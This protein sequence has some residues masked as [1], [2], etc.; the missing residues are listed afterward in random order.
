MTHCA[1]ARRQVQGA[2]TVIR[3]RSICTPDEPGT[4]VTCDDGKDNDCDGLIDAAD[5][6]CQV[7]VPDETPEQSCFDGNDNDCDELVD[8]ADTADCDGAIGATDHLWCWRLRASGNRPARAVAR[9]IPAHRVHRV[10]KVRRTMHPA[11]TAS[12]MTV[13]A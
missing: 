12:M 2:L 11:V 10:L 1:K 5:P 6:D 4:E 9:W 13:T 7:C 3:L 8:C